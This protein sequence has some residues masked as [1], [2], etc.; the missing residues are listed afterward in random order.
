MFQLITRLARR[1]TKP[2]T[3]DFC[4]RKAA[5]DR[6][7]KIQKLEASNKLLRYENRSHME[8]IR[9]LESKLKSGKL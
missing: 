9:V 4:D 1:I 6:E 7:K 5:L 2:T 3:C 8:R